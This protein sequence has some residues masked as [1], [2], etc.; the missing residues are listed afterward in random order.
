MVLLMKRRYIGNLNISFEGVEGEGL[1]TAC[2]IS[3]GAHALVQV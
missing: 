2:C 3:S 1:L